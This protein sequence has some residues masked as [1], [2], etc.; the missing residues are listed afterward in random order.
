MCTQHNQG[1]CRTS[2]SKLNFLFCHFA[3][4]NTGNSALSGVFVNNALVLK[5]VIFNISY[6]KDNVKRSRGSVIGIE[7]GYGLDDRWIGVAVP[8]G[9]TISSSPRRSDRLWSPPNFL[10]NRYRLSPGLKRPGREADHS[11]Q[12]SAEVKKM[13]IYTPT[14]PYAFMA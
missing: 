10:S 12:A 4:N 2:S 13:W 7:T 8:L 9:A 3:S 6:C 5:V 11:A 14:L 1:P